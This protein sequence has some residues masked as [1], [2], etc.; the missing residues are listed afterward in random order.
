MPRSDAFA[1][2]RMSVPSSSRTLLR[3]ICAMKRHDLVGELDVLE[4]RLLADDGD[5]RLELRRLDVGDEAPLEARDEPLLH[6]VELLR[7][8]VARDDDLLARLVEGVERVEE[9]FLRLRLAREEVDVVDEE[10][11]ALLAVARAE[12]VHLLVL[13]RLDELVHEALGAD[14]DDARARPLLA[15]AVRDG[16]DQVRLAEAGAAADEERVV[17]APADARGRHRRGVGELVGRPDDEVRE[18]VLRV[19]PLDGRRATATGR[20]GSGTIGWTPDSP[21]RDAAL[22]ERPAARTHRERRAG[23]R[24]RTERA[25]PRRDARG[26]PSIVQRTWMLSRVRSRRR[27]VERRQEVVLDPL[28]HELVARAQAQHAVGQAVELHAGEPLVEARGRL[29]A[30]E[31]NG[32]G[33]GSL[34]LARHVSA[35]AQRAA[36]HRRRPAHGFASALAPL[37]STTTQTLTL[38]SP[39]PHLLNS[40]CS[41]ERQRGPDGARAAA[42]PARSLPIPGLAAPGQPHRN[43]LPVLLFR[44]VTNGDGHHKL[45]TGC[46]EGVLGRLRTAGPATRPEVRWQ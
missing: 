41:R 11:V 45:S 46:G 24:A 8:L 43:V 40:R 21:S 10:Q 33:P 29:L 15:D 12:V 23:A 39:T 2:R 26:A 13:Q 1:A 7:V 28:A 18:R 9:L 27:S 37:P 38:T 17:P 20:G 3:T 25:D 5:A 16:V 14:V 42:R 34:R 36:S 6:L 4:L 19:E 44:L 30:R 22:R 31:G 35:P 32:F